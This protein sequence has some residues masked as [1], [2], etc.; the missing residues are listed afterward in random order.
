MKVR[1]P[2]SMAFLRAVRDASSR[3]GKG[4]SQ[5]MSVPL[6]TAARRVPPPA[7]ERSRG[8]RRRSRRFSQERRRHPPGASGLFVPVRGASRSRMSFARFVINRCLAPF[9]AKSVPR[10][11]ASARAGQAPA[12]LLSEGRPRQG[13]PL[14][15]QALGRK[16]DHVPQQIRV[17]A[18]LNQA[19]Q[20][21]YSIGHRWFFRYRLVQATRPRLDDH[22]WLPPRRRPTATAL[23]RARGR[24]SPLPRSYTTVTDTTLIRRG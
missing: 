23:R 21:R 14:F 20:A 22:R 17:G 2:P 4:V 19:A 18:P 1:K 9:Q 10:S 8:R 15:H 13:A 12:T 5:F 24:A 11:R 6:R 3:W 7:L 16:A